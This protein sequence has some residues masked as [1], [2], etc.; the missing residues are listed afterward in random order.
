MKE[1]SIND[2]GVQLNLSTAL[3]KL[4]NVNNELET[5]FK[6]I[7]GFNSDRPYGIM[8]CSNICMVIG[9]TDIA[10]T[11]LIPFSNTESKSRIP[12]LNYSVE[13][14][15][16]TCKYSTE[17]M[18][19]ILQVFKILDKN[20]SFSVMQEFPITIENEDFKFILAPVVDND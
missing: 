13:D 8:D 16:K 9:K 7:G 5:R 17:F 14:K 10:K 6:D 1:I 4:F 19:K 2:F 18:L 15:L 20:P 3:S 11:L 12:E